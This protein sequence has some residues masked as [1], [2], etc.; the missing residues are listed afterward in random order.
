MLDTEEEEEGAEDVGGAWWN[1]GGFIACCWWEYL[2]SGL[3]HDAPYLQRICADPNPVVAE[4]D[5]EEETVLVVGVVGWE[6]A[7]VGFLMMIF[8]EEM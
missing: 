2:Q 4:V 6:N 5:E 8:N 3:L 1:A 7:H